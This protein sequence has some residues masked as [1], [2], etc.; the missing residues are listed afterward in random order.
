MLSASAA[1]AEGGWVPIGPTGVGMVMDLAAGRSA[2]YAA[3]CNGVYRS[4]DGG[5][6]WHEAGLQRECVLRL[7]VDARS[8]TIYAIV[9][10]HFFVSYYP[11]PS[12]LLSNLLLGSSLW[13]SR[14]GGRTWTRAPFETAMTVAVDP[15]EPDTAYVTSYDSYYPL[16]VTRDSGASWTRVP[17]VPGE[18]I[19]G[20]AIDARDG[21]IY[22]A[23]VRLVER[24]QGVW[25]AI[26]LN[27]S[28]VAAGSASDG[29]VYAVGFEKFCRKTTA[30]PAW[31]CNRFPGSNGMSIV[32]LPESDSEPRRVFVA[33]FDG[34]W[35]SDDGGG[36]WSHAAGYP[37]S[38]TPAIALDP[39]GTVV[40]AG[41][42]VGVYRS[43]DR[44]ET[45]ASSSAGLRSSWIRALALD[46]V[47]PATIWA[48]A[49][50]RAFDV[51]QD[52]PGL[53]RSTDGGGS[54]T[55]ASVAGDPG[56]VFSLGIDATDRRNLYT[57]NSGSVD[58]THD[59]GASWSTSSTSSHF[60]FG[61]AVDPASSSNVW[62]ATVG[63]LKKSNNRGQTWSHS[64]EE[65]I[66]SLLFDSRRP[67]TIYAGAAWEDAGFYYPFGAGFAVHT[68]RDGGLT[69]TP[70][71]SE[72]EGAVTALATDPFSENDVYAGT[73]AGTIL[74]SPD[75]GATWERWDT[76]FPG[77]PVMAL[78]ADPV[79]PG[80]LYRAG[81]GGVFRSE[82]AGRTWHYFSEGL[83]PYGAFGLA[84]S[85]DGA[86]LYAGTT[87]GGVFQRNLAVVD[88]GTV[89]RVDQPRAPRDVPP[90]PPP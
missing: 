7:A 11:E 34:V 61:L 49:E 78:L 72:L 37:V 36:T 85:P 77:Y 35:S 2:V 75:A 21:S 8:D 83:F 25:S 82:D 67:G 63:G 74:R 51:F 27:V 10:P 71:G 16:A 60:V 12:H 66:F 13:V 87:G 23:S 79:R 88:R 17:E 14:D 9:D 4:S 64:L 20:L 15:T 54:W 1:T 53:F 44:G 26:E 58:H 29:A 86:W 55:S 48:G 68:S 59:G 56:Y 46:P 32:E 89:T 62:A 5:S 22:G 47:E 41:N 43:P 6:R 76:Q 84:V 65:D 40:Y 80:R 31:N 90:R 50:R 81:W 45:W 24:V 57:G 69:W 3:T 19:T 18:I 39:S 42:D 28:A 33:G 70:A 73:V 52:V 38:Y 30:A